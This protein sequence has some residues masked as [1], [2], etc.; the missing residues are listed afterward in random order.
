MG[1]ESNGNNEKERQ[2]TD[3]DPIIVSKNTDDVTKTKNV[4]WRDIVVDKKE[5]QK[6]VDMNIL[7]KQSKP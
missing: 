2:T 1:V 6:N 7:L 3:K 5:D 4:T